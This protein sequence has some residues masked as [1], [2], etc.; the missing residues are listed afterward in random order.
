MHKNNN[1]TTIFNG[2]CLDTGAAMSLV[3]KAQL[4]AYSKSHK[5]RTTL[6]K[7]LHSFRFR[8]GAQQSLGT[9]NARLPIQNGSF[10][11]FKTA[12]VTIEVP[13]ILR[14]EVFPEYCLLLDF[15]DS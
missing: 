7:S 1:K 11:E 13:F 3:G 10:L 14:L 6:R 8:R 5:S 4:E 2:Y 9:L 15:Q 12:V